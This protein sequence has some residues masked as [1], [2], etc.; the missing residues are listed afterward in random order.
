MEIL[1]NTLFNNYEIRILGTWEEPWF[2]A[3]DIYRILDNHNIT[4]LMK[5]I[6]P[7][8][9]CY[10]RVHTPN[11]GMQESILVNEPGLYKIIMRSNKPIAQQFQNWICEDVLPSIRKKGFYKLEEEL[12]KK[13]AQEMLTLMQKTEALESKLLDVTKSNYQFKQKFKYHTFGKGAAVYVI[14]HKDDELNKMK[15]KIGFDSKNV[16][17][18]LNGL[19]TAIPYLK[20]ERIIY[21][22]DYKLLE[23]SLHRKYFNNRTYEWIMDIPIETILS[24]IDQILTLLNLT[25]KFDT[26][27]ETYNKQ[28]NLILEVHSKRRLAINK[29]NYNEELEKQIIEQEYKIQFQDE[30][31][32]DI[33]PVNIEK[34]IQTKVIER[35]IEL[36]ESTNQLKEKLKKTKL[37]CTCRKT[38]C[39]SEFHIAKRTSDGLSLRCKECRAEY[40]LAKRKA[41]P[42]TQPPDTKQCP[43]CQ[44]T[45]PSSNFWRNPTRKDGLNNICTPCAKKHVEIKTNKEKIVPVEK[46]CFKCKIVKSIDEYTIRNRNLDGHDGK[47]KA[48]S[49]IYH[50]QRKKKLE[51]LNN[52]EL[53]V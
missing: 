16:N 14:S 5:K 51:A 10:G 2:V 18:R 11:S 24:E 50:A 20:V 48:C 31:I 30:E 49:S 12:N 23:K 33:T 21:T 6:P 25:Y 4:Q 39:I 1:D 29:E 3:K 47:C 46:A 40:S 27:I 17:D 45:Q 34:E 37:C 38:L 26:T 22:P 8:W 53:V 9:Q 28:V 32:L 41:K 42:Y 52:P 35:T 19:R 44:I 7:E 43:E 15:Y 36:Q 13:H